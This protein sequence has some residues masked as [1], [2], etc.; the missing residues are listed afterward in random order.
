MV[1]PR[2]RERAGAG[3]CLPDGRAL[4]A[5]RR[6]AC[7]QGAWAV[8]GARAALDAAALAAPRAFRGADGEE[9]RGRRPTAPAEEALAALTASPL[10]TS[11]P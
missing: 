5:P 4:T 7:Q 10:P 11:L 3:G 2:E 1:P 9:E 8:R 6:A